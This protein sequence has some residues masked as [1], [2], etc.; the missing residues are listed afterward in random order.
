MHFMCGHC[1]HRLLIRGRSCERPVREGA[2][3]TEAEARGKW[4]GAVLWKNA[5]SFEMEKVRDPV[6]H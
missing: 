1:N 5:G 6:L 3:T 2:V 4:P